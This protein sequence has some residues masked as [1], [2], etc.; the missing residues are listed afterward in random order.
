MNTSIPWR[1]LWRSARRAGSVASGGATAPF[2]CGMS[3]DQIP[4]RCAAYKDHTGSRDESLDFSN[5]GTKLVSASD[6]H[7]LRLWPVPA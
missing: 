4:T 1:S 3:A 7:T 2:G 5:D 6:D